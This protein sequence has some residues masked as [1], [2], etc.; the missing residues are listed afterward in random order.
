MN[1]YENLK[2]YRLMLGCTQ[3]EM[4]VILGLSERGYRYYEN[5]QREPDLTAL[6]T[7][8]D[9]LKVSLDD[10][11]GR[12]F[13]AATNLND[14]ISSLCPYLDQLNELGQEIAIERIAELTEIPKYQRSSED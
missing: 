6:V 10:L 13:P 9:Y 8:A 14:L 5:G 3:K 1:F 12:E 4:S 7:I 11:I 2:T